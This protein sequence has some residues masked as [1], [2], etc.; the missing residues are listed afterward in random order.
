MFV[1]GLTAT[2]QGPLS[3]GTVA[4]MVFVRP[5]ITDTLFAWVLTT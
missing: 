3:A 1:T 2:A 4:A 5:S